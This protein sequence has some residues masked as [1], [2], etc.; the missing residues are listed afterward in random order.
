ML[1]G[2]IYLL[3]TMAL[4]YF[5]HDGVG[6]W[7]RR[8]CWSLTK[9][10]QFP[11][12]ALGQAEATRSLLEIQLSPQV[13]VKSTTTQ[14]SVYM[15][16]RPERIINVQNGAWIQL[17]LA[18]AVRGQLV[19]FNI[20]NSKSPLYILPVSKID[21]SVQVPFLDNGK[22]TPANK[23]ETAT[24]RAKSQQQEAN[25]M[26]EMPAKGEDIV[27]NTWVPL[28][29]N[30]DYIELQIWYPSD[31]LKPGSKDTGYL[32]QL[33]LDTSGK[34]Q[35]DGLTLTELQVKKSSRADAS[36]LVVAE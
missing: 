5:K 27:W 12:N 29:E 13:Y 9:T 31:L 15:Y 20:I 8:C 10:D 7:L 30:A 34:T 1:L 32:Y 21:D 4:N 28:S 16:N 35:A 17:K 23:F 3:A 14:K 19:E 6:W 36:L 26:I 18:N 11:D 24:N 22:F 33:E 2:T 25:N